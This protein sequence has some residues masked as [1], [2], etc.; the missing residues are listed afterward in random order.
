MCP[1]YYLTTITAESNS[2]FFNMKTL[3]SLTDYERAKP[4]YEIR[5]FS[6][7]DCNSK[8]NDAILKEKISKS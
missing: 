6:P 1:H 4:C 5:P 8:T 2:A 7:D 3:P